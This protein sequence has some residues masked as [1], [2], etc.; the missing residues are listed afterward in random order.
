MQNPD[1]G[2]ASYELVRGNKRLE[3]L[4]T[5]E[6]F[7]ELTLYGKVIGADVGGR[8]YYDRV[9]VSR[10][11]SGLWEVRA[12][13]IGSR[14]T[15]SAIS[16][17]LQYSSH[18]PDYRR[19]DIEYVAWGHEGDERLTLEQSYC[20]GRHPIRPQQAE[21]R[22]IVARL[23]VSPSLPRPSMSALMSR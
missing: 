23:M 16:A 11:S 21:T 15:T 20:Q 10:V 3:W 14:C 1:G 22:W 19:K 4:N 17:L 6:V 12:A 7:G 13:L 8:G 18:S 2:F 5:A 9:Y